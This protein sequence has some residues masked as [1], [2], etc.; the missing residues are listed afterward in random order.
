MWKYSPLFRSP[1]QL[2]A[3]EKFLID[4][5]M[6]EHVMAGFATGFVSHFEYATP[7]P[8]GHVKNYPL[9]TT[10]Q[11]EAKLRAVMGEQIRAGKMIGGK[12]WSAQDVQRFFGGQEFYGIP[13]NATTKGRDPL[14]RI[15]H[16][17]G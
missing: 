3:L 10:P 14:G 12:G 1:I 9:V 2:A 8:W 15:V 16:D 7:I 5:P 4:D 17:Y 11:G 6:K 13:C